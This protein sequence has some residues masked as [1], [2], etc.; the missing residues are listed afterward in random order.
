MASA[1]AALAVEAILTASS[2]ASYSAECLQYAEALYSFSLANPG[3]GYSGG[4]YNSSGYVDKEAWAAIWLYLATGT[5][6]YINHIVVH[7]R[8][9]QLHRLPGQHRPEHH[10]PPGRT[11][12]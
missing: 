8:Q 9:R 2:N 7:R 4:F 3:T 12:G 10:R 1:A 5:W 6:S 11:P